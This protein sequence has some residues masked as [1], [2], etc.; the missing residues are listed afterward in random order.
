MSANNEQGIKFE[1]N[2]ELSQQW[3][4]PDKG[5]FYIFKPSRVNCA[6]HGEVGEFSVAWHDSVTGET[7]ST[8][9]IC[10]RCWID[11]IK[12]SVSPVTPI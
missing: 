7:Y 5:T 4:V 3:R 12:A 1:E 6:I 11:S 2:D 10:P 8:G 9:Q